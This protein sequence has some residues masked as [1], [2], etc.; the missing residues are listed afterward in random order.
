MAGGYAAQPQGIQAIVALIKDINK[1]IDD[2]NKRV[3]GLGI[4][5]DPD[6]NIIMGTSGSNIIVK[7]GSSINVE[8]DGNLNVDGDITVGGT[9]SFGGT[10]TIG[11]NAAITGTLSLPAGIIS[12]AALTSP[13]SP[14]TAHSDAKGFAVPVGSP[15]VTACSTTVTPPAGFTR[16]VI[17]ASASLSAYNST[18]SADFLYVGI[19]VAGIA[20]PGW[21]PN[22]TVP[23]H[24]YG[25]VTRGSAQILTGLT[26]ASFAITCEVSSETAAWATDSSNVAN[27]DAMILYLR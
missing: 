7:G 4:Q 15:F 17:S 25:A 21:S 18:A 10:T 8:D 14:A 5:I 2:V 11:G 1:R 22:T 26:G 13:V 6:G 9:A 19:K 12:N 3:T 20:A 16:A 24:A 23:S 27:I